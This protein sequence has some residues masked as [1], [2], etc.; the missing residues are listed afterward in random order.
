MAA[1]DDLRNQ[2]HAATR[3]RELRE[4]ALADEQGEALGATLKKVA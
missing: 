3:V 1:L 4:A 2:P